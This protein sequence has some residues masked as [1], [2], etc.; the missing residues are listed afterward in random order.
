M[1]AQMM[2]GSNV[3]A[4]DDK[5]IQ[6]RSV[7]RVTFWSASGGDVQLSVLTQALLDVGSTAEPPGEVTP[8]VALHR[9]VEEV[10]KELGC[11]PML[12]AAKHVEVDPNAKKKE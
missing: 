9:A 8:K 5:E 2:N 6:K 3:I 12:L 7:G 10:A 11:E 1:V 4:I